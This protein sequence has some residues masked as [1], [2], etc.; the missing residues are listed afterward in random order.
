M[1]HGRKALTRQN[2]GKTSRLS[3]MPS[4]IVKSTPVSPESELA[5]FAL[6]GP[7]PLLIQILRAA[8][9]GWLQLWRWRTGERL[10]QL[11]H[12][13]GIHDW[14]ALQLTPD[15]AEGF[16]A[17]TNTVNCYQLGASGG[18]STVPPLCPR[19]SMPGLRLWRDRFLV[20][21]VLCDREHAH[22]HH[23]SIHPP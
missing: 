2:W 8:W 15:E 23:S 12:R 3:W 14:P 11:S 9:R 21:C 1:L 19:V 22:W 16:H 4:A 18:E 13:G 17:V 10:L 6:I 5:Y 20:L 7:T